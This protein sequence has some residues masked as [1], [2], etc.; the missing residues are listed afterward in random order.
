V[1]SPADRVSGGVLGI[2]LM[3]VAACCNAV[4]SVLQRRASRDEPSS[5]ELHPRMIGNLLRRPVWLFGVLSMIV[6]FVLH[7][8]AIAVSRIALVQPLLIA[9][10]PLT[11]LL[12]AWV[13]GL[14]LRLADVLAIAMA[15]VGLAAFEVCLAPSGGDPG[16]VSAAGWLIASAATVGAVGV[17][18]LL[19]YR[20]RD[21]HR[22]ALLGIATGAAFGFNSS[23]I[24][25]IGAHVSQTGNLFTAWQTYAVAVVGPAGFFL[26]QNALAAGNLMSSQPGL[27]LTNPLVATIW[28]MVVF[29]EHGRGSLTWTLGAVGGGLLIVGATI[30]LARSPLLDPDS[31]R[32]Q[33]TAA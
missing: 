23:L 22:A 20:G 33:Q 30:M 13:F 29:G 3:L 31:D 16:K 28:G 14:R 5:A 25:G 21:E 8:I 19:G 11:L 27:T 10:L 7:G 4:A 18:I 32:A 9:E 15:S 1:A 6:G 17:L 26:L 2:G 12:A 24:A